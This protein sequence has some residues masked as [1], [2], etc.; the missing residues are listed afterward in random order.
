MTLNNIGNTVDARISGGAIVN[1]MGAVRVTATETALIEG[2]AGAVAVSGTVGVGAGVTTNTITSQTIA[3]IEAATVESLTGG[4]DVLATATRTIDTLTVGFAGGGELA[5]AGTFAALSVGGLVDA[6][7]SS[8]A[9]IDAF[10]DIRVEATSTFS[11]DVDAG[12]GAVGVG[13]LGFGGTAIVAFLTMTTTTAFVSGSSLSAGGDIN[14]AATTDVTRFDLD[15]FAGA[16]G[17]VGIEAA[18]AE[19]FSQSVTEA[20][21][22]SGAIVETADRLTIRADSSTILDANASGLGVGAAAVGV[23]FADARETGMSA[24]SLAADVS[25]NDLTV[26]ALLTTSIDTDGT[27]VQGGIGTGALNEST[28]RADGQVTAAVD[29]GVIGVTNQVTVTA[30]SEANAVADLFGLSSA[31]SRLAAVSP[32]P[33]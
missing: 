32:A 31:A 6:H 8:N 4:I 25:V 10:T 24:A 30:T 22:D 20:A 26:E 5:L 15:A 29:S 14:V 17:F 11:L 18:V 19:L 3:R 12:A 23:V 28:A 21:V 1:A 16:G 2:F 9:D 27:A 33:R 13:T 7:I